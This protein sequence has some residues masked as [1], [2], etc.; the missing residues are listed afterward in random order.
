MRAWVFAILFMCS[1]WTVVWA[2][3]FDIT[4]V[5]LR[6]GMNIKDAGLPPTEKEDFQQYDAYAIMQLPWIFSESPIPNLT[7]QLMGSAGALRG[8]DE[9]AFISTLTTGFAYHNPEWRIL[10]DMGLGVAGVSRH[11]FGRQDIGGPFQFIAHGGGG[12][13]IFKKTILGYRFHHMSDATIFGSSRWVDLHMIDLR[14]L[15]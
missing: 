15:F 2:G 4:G 6:A 11:Q 9:T 13:E 12:F 10:L 7:W 14:Y 5:G 3:D 8:D 1:S